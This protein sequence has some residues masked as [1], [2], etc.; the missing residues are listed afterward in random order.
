MYSW[1]ISPSNSIFQTS[2]QSGEEIKYNLDKMSY[3]N[4]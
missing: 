2:M 3:L 1:K 4:L